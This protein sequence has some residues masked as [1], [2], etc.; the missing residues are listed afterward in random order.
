VYGLGQ[1]GWSVGNGGP[2]GGCAA[3]HEVVVPLKRNG[4]QDIPLLQEKFHVTIPFLY[5]SAGYGLLFNNGGYGTVS[6]R[7]DGSTAWRADAV[8]ALDLWITA[9]DDAPEIYH[10]YADAT[11]H[12]PPLRE[13]AM[14]FWQSRNRYKSSRIALEVADRYRRLGLADH[15]GVVVV[16]YKNQD[17]DGDFAPGKTCFPSVRALSDGI[18]ARINASTVFSFWPEVLTQ[19][20]EFKTLADRSCLINADLGGLAV[21]AT[22]RDCRDFIWRT[23]LKPRYFDQ[24]VTAYW[25]DET[26]GEGTGGGDGSHGYDTSLGPAAYASNYWV[27]DWLAMFSDPVAAEGKEPPLVLTRSVWAGG[28]RHGVVLWSSDIESTFAELRAQLN[29]GVHASLSG[30]PW[31]TSDV[32]GYGCSDLGCASDIDGCFGELIS[33]WYQFGAF[34]PVFRT[35]GCRPQNDPDTCV[36]PCQPAQRSCGP[37]EVWSYGKATQEILVKYIQVRS[38][39]KPYIAELS[40]NVTAR[41]VPTVRPLWWEFPDAGHDVDD[42]YLLGPDLLVAPVATQGATSRSIVFPGSPTVEW[43]SLWDPQTVVKG[44]QTKTIDAPLATIPVYKRK[45]GA[46]SLDGVVF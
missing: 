10:S 44:G 28:Q 31:W 46:K 13:D 25:L 16:D 7:D 39:L 32:G 11:G 12:A 33:R 22:R 20:S 21:D 6:V 3:N 24:G 8:V 38:K 43:E 4:R 18:R 15:V 5:S 37:N 19:S 9:G 27:N 41:G 1:G 35:H 45:G 26:D 17:H 14:I 36:A 40:R 34:S 29:L 42:Q 2:G 30:I 23:M